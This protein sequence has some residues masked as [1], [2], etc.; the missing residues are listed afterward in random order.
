MLLTILLIVLLFEVSILL[1][2]AVIV[3]LTLM[4]MVEFNLHGLQFL[5]YDD[6]A[7]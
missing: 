5:R 3:A 4:I 1:A 6:S 2:L 7:F